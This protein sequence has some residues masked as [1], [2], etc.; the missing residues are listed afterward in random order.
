MQVR[1][2]PPIADWPT[3]NARRPIW[4]GHQ[5]K[6]FHPGILAKYLAVSA[7]SAKVGVPAA[8]VAVDQDVYNPL[9]L[10]IP[11]RDGDRLSVV[12]IALGP[13]MADVP[14]GM[15]PPARAGA[16]AKGLNDW[17]RNAVTTPDHHRLV[18]AF[19]E[20]EKESETLA[21]QMDGVLLRLLNECFSALPGAGAGVYTPSV[22]ASRLLD[23][24][25]EVLDALLHD[26]AACAKAYNDAVAQFPAAGVAR[27]SVE[28]DRIEVPLWALTWKG[29]RRR[30]YVDVADTTPML[31][32][33]D[34]EPV[35]DSITL[36]PRALLMTALLRR[37][38][39]CSLFIH[40]TG[41]GEYDRITER[42][43]QAWRSE[44]IAPMAVVTADVHLDFDAPVNDGAA[45]RRAVWKA[46]HLPH[47]LDLALGL[48]DSPPESPARE[49]RELLEH[50]DD[51]R[52]KK[53]RRAAF[54]L[55]HQINA[56]LAA[57]HPE[58]IVAAQHE[59]ESARHGV[60]NAAIVR[61]RDWPF[62]LYPREKL[63]TLRGRLT[64]P[65]VSTPVS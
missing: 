41:G 32:T 22:M 56:D 43:W 33:E 63:E 1:S 20:A 8:Q 6:L 52:D 36:A 15:Q 19:S 30:V 34:G 2:D 49:K 23:R 13:I 42:W 45:L 27:L 55:I 39:R 12:K 17:P 65:S 50:M 4:T 57:A 3:P 25:D 35:E 53:R 48:Q 9:A 54:E 40:G 46:H 18:A 59:L 51:D 10:S 64:Y 21:Q 11:V 26:A 62:L 7:A 44:K 60:A 47:N 16:V 5:L 14:V 38:Q 24:E 58:A 29:P 37:P 28:P 61:R 31:V